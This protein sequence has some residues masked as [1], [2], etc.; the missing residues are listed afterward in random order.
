KAL[1][2]LGPKHEFSP[3]LEGCPQ[4]LD[5]HLGMITVATSLW[6]VYYIL[7]ILMRKY[8]HPQQDHDRWAGT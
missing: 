4:L 7:V 1:P 3:N 2:R 6:T 5:T 8:V